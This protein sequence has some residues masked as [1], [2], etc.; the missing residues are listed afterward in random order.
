M[1]EKE[2]REWLVRSEFADSMGR[3]AEEL[4]DI[5]EAEPDD[6]GLIECPLLPLREMVM[7]PHMVT[8]LFVGREKSLAAIHAAQAA[9][10]TLLAVTQINPDVEDPGANDWFPVGVEVAVG[11]MLRMPD[12]SSSVLAQGRRRVQIISI[13]QSEPYYIAKARVVEEPTGKPR[14]TEALMRCRRVV[15]SKVSRM[16]WRS[17]TSRLMVEATRSAS[18]P[19]SSMFMAKT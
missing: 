15:G 4:Y 1:L 14:E 10:R 16:D 2:Y 19:G 9:N 7:F 18:Q 8:P 3:R 12:N 6:D 5:A 13:S 11:R 17:A